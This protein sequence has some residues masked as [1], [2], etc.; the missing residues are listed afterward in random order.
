MHSKV[1]SENVM[2]DIDLKAVN[3]REGGQS[4]DPTP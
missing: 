2:S 3:L 4:G 1:N